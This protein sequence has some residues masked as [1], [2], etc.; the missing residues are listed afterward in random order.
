MMSVRRSLLAAAGVLAGLV[1]TLAIAVPA[2][3]A[4]APPANSIAARPVALAAVSPTIDP[5]AN[6]VIHLPH[7]QQ[8]SCPIRNFCAGVNDPTRNDTKWFFL[9]H[10]HDYD[11]S[12]WLG[13]GAFINNQTNPNG[14]VQLEDQNHQ[15]VGDPIPVGVRGAVFWTPVWHID[16]CVP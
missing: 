1:V 8:P 2:R 5:A 15:P 16:S 12:N 10:C 7:G 14:E 9:F 3:A 11:L 13:T 6:T 4:G